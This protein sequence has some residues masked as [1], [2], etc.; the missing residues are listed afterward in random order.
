MQALLILFRFGRSFC[1]FLLIKMN[2][3]P[4]A[5]EESR[6]PGTSTARTQMAALMIHGT[7]I[8]IRRI[9]RLRTRNR[10]TRRRA[11]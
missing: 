9:I 10:P 3:L 2:Q 6:G 7:T 4:A 8:L 1:D 5:I 11:P